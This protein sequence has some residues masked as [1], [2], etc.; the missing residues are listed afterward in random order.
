MARVSSLRVMAMAITALCLLPN[1]VTAASP[2]TRAAQLLSEQLRKAQYVP[3]ESDTSYRFVL[4]VAAL[5]EK[6]QQEYPLQLVGHQGKAYFVA[7]AQPTAKVFV[8]EKTYCSYDLNQWLCHA[9]APTAFDQSLR[10]PRMNLYPPT[11][12]YLLLDLIERHASATVVSV[13]GERTVA[14]QACTAFR[15]A[16][17]TTQLSREVVAKHLYLNFDSPKALD[18]LTGASA[19]VCFDK[20]TGQALSYWNEASIDQAAMVTDGAIPDATQLADQPLG[21]MRGGFEATRVSASAPSVEAFY[22]VP[23]E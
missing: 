7:S 5:G 20:V 15:V 21:T 13:A 1:F 3:N 8:A 10:S 12:M 6:Q 23:K 16:F 9:I 19:E 2:T 14:G 4:D 22:Q 18:Y 17:D 11:A